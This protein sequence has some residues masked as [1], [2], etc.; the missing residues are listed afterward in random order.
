MLI[1]DYKYLHGT[2]DRGNYVAIPELNRNKASTPQ[3]INLA[4]LDI[5]LDKPTAFLYIDGV[6]QSPSESGLNPVDIKNYMPR[7]RSCS[8]FMFHEWIRTFEGNE[9][10]VKVDTMS[11]TCAAGIQAMYEAQR[12]L[13]DG[14]IKEVVIIGSERITESTLSLFSEINIPVVCGDGFVYLKLSNDEEGSPDPYIPNDV[15]WKYTHQRNPFVFPKEVLAT[16]IPEYPV[17]YVKLHATGTEAN[18]EAESLLSEIA[19]PITYKQ[20]IGH[21]QGISSLLE[22]CLMLDDPSISGKVLVVANG[23]GGFYGSFTVII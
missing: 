3:F 14:V 19:E 16:L 23:L 6:S 15:K 2:E 12:L 18:T 11:G 7:V 22:T 1:I 8:A 9:H 4:D 5:T 20:L 10:L 17:D 21:T 13:N